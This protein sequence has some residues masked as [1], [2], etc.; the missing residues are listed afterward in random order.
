MMYYELSSIMF[1]TVLGKIYML[2]TY[3]VLHICPIA[4]IFREQIL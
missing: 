2:V 1:G 3:Q 4:A